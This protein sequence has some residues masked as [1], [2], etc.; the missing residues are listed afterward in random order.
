[1]ELTGTDTIRRTWHQP[2]V[3][4]QSTRE[5]AAAWLRDHAAHIEPAGRDTIARWLE[6]LGTV[7]AG[8]MSAE[9]VRI[10]AAGYVTLL[11]G[12]PAYQFT[13]FTLKAAALAF[14]WFPALAELAKLLDA[15]TDE[16]AQQV[17]LARAVVNR[18]APRREVFKP[19]PMGVRLKA[20]ADSYARVYGADDPR[21]AAAAA[22]SAA[23]VDQ[24]A[25]KSGDDGF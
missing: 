18:E 22:R 5:A 3:V 19:E 8:T 20:I 7:A 1:M 21:S 9:E 13:K 11:D 23:Y 10:K 12:R 17:R 4:T 2:P 15:Q 6:A 16:K 14:T 25:V 24:A